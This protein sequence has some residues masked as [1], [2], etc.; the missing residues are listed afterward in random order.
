VVLISPNAHWLVRGYFVTPALGWHQVKG[1]KLAVSAY[2]VLRPRRWRSRV[3][4]AAEQGLSA[5]RHRQA[6]A[7]GIVVRQKTPIRVAIEHLTIIAL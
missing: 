2:E 5:C 4:V 1:K 7:G 6:D 3:P